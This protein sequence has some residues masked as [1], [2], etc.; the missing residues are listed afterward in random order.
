MRDL[1][2]LKERIDQAELQLKAAEN[3]RVRE[4]DSLMKMW[5]QIRQR[6]ATQE[7][8]IANYRDKVTQ[9]M[10]RNEDLA[11]MV[12]TMLRTV[13]ASATGPRDETAAKIGSLAEELLNNDYPA[14]T[15]QVLED[16]G[17]EVAEDLDEPDDVLELNVAAEED[18]DARFEAD[19]REPSHA[20]SGESRSPGIRS[21]VGRFEA[22]MHRSVRR[23]RGRLAEPPALSDDREPERG[24][25]ELENLRHELQ[26][27]RRRMTEAS[28]A[29]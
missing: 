22:A 20:A 8:E 16:L 11:Q 5:R 26:G 9:L 17:D 24:P 28:S 3:D 21:L 19:D 12:E 10:R 1:S 2:A 27:L 29:P 4:S 25:H 13:E 23:D 6:F 18:P 15:A 14:R 7:Q